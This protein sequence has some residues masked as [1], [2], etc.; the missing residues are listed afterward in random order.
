MP[1]TIYIVFS[2]LRA[3]NCELCHD[4]FCRHHHRCKQA[5]G[6]SLEMPAPGVL[7]WKTPSGRTYTTTPTQYPV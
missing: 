6:W 5:Q 4:P 2:Q 3:Y 7:K 1:G